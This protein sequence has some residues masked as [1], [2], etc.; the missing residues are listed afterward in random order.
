MKKKII[1]AI[2]GGLLIFVWQFLSHNVLQMHNDTEMYTSKQDS[3]LS[4]LSSQFSAD[5]E[6]VM[7]NLPPGATG[8]EMNKFV[9]SSKGKPWVVIAY[10]QSYNFDMTMALVRTGLVDIAMVLLLCWILFELGSAGFG[11]IFLCSVFTGLI[12]FMS[13]PYTAHIWFQTA[14]INADLIDAIASWGLCGL[15]LGWW[16]RRK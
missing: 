1:G 11:K 14:G 4:Y 8:D 2:V 6:Y 9:V 10:H 15:W 3:I 16:L 13:E 12:A 7:P 5:G